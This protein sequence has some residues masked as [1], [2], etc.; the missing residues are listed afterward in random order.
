MANIYKNVQKL[1]NAAGS[2]VDMYESPTATASIINANEGVD[3]LTFNNIIVLEAGDKLK[4]Q[5]ATADKIKMTAS[6]LQILRTQPTD[7]I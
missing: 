4:M 1:L 7:Q 3:L 5:C 2:D 6:L